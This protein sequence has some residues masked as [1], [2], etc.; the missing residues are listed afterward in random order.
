MPAS[1]GR[2]LGKASRIVRNQVAGKL[3]AVE[4]LLGTGGLGKNLTPPSVHINSSNMPASTSQYIGKA[5]RASKDQVAGKLWSVEELCGT[6]YLCTYLPVSF[7]S[8]NEI[9]IG[10]VIPPPHHDLNWVAQR[11]SPRLDDFNSLYISMLISVLVIR[12]H[13]TQQEDILLCWGWISDQI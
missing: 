3:W 12:S 10:A 2:S 11:V 7:V 13:I 4:E 9:V 8:G 5:N 6:G 1:T